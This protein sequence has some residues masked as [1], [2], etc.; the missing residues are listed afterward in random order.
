MID[1]N[2]TKLVEEEK[3]NRNRVI[4]LFVFATL[5]VVTLIVINFAYATA[6]IPPG[7][8]E[9]RSEQADIQ[10]WQAMGEAYFGINQP[11]S[12]I[13]A[14]RWQA[15]GEYYSKQSVS[16]PDLKL[17][18]DTDAARLQ[19]LGEAYTRINLPVSQVDAA[20]WQAMGEYYS[21]Q[22]ISVVHFDP[23][24]SRNTDAAR[25]QALG[26]AY[27]EIN[28]KVGQADAARWQAMGEYYSKQSASTPYFDPKL[29]R[30][31]DA[32]RWQALGEA[33][34][35]IKLEVDEADAAR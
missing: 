34:S 31:T 22:S 10:R 19:A 11:V 35:R 28:L 23:L 3:M 33:F 12:Q 4:S 17:S 8:R 13:D 6:N 27:T 26:E 16:I 30:D 20:R 21:K 18:R 25:L 15:L 29:S 14:A 5:I 9:A 2:T 24:L 7:V 1:T 32:A